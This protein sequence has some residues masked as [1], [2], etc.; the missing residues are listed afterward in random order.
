VV[1]RPDGSLS[2]V[3]DAEKAAKKAFIE[4]AFLSAAA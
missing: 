4:D 1:L 3:L 2:K